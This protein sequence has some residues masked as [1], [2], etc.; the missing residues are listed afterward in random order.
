MSE[1]ST[2]AFPITIRYADLDSH[3]HGNNA[4]VL[5]YL[6]SAR[7]GFYQAIDIWHP[8]PGM[9]TGMV[10]AHIDIDYLKPILFTDQVQVLLELTSIGNK[11]FTLAF[12][13]ETVSEHTP[14]ARGSTVMVVY[15]NNI[16]ASIPIPGDW[17]KKLLQFK[18]N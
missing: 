3:G 13:V 1:S 6:E 16:D 15:D 12:S 7:L 14:L 5:T 4:A 2:Y 8:S 9:Y 18:F 17:R 11:S 10:V